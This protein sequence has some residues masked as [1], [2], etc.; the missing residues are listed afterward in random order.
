MVTTEHLMTI[1]DG[2]EVLLFNPTFMPIGV[3]SFTP[4]PDHPPNLSV[5][6]I[7]DFLGNDT[8]M[9]VSP[10][11][12]DGIKQ[13]DQTMCRHHFVGLHYLPYL[14]QHGKYVLLYGFD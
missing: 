12:N 3:P 1:T 4:P 13:T 10:A 7:E 14:G 11:P 9:I 5:H 8:S 2:F 6:I